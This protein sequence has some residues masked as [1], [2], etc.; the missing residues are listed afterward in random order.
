MEF[1][2]PRF[3]Y[4]AIGKTYSI[5][6]HEITNILNMLEHLLTNMIYAVMET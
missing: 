4:F 1:L 2:P 6:D 3:Y 5:G